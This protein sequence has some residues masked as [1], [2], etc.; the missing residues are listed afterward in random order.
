MDRFDRLS[1]L[2]AVNLRWRRQR[3]WT[4]HH[5]DGRCHALDQ[6]YAGRNVVDLHTHGDTLGKAH[7]GENGIDRSEARLARTRVVHV[8]AA[9]HTTHMSP[10]LLGVAHQ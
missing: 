7:P 1:E 2:I 10:D 3:A 9:R 5:F 8:D 6:S 4:R